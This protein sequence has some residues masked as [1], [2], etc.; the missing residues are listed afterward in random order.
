[1]CAPCRSEYGR[2]HYRANRQRYID[3]EAQRKRTR[4]KNR[5]RW[6]IGF[7]RTHPCVDCGETDP[8]VLEFDHLRD[9]LFEVMKQFASRNWQEILDEIEK[10]DVVCSNCHRRRTARRSKSLRYV[11][12][13]S[14][15]ALEGQDPANL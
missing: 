13:Q 12:T 2:E 8:I 7:F 1:M 10:C 6:L 5:T 9:K 15:H 3:A 4:A 11:L 14:D